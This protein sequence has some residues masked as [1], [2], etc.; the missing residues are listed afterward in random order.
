M[1]KDI[2]QRLLT[3]VPV[4]SGELY[5]VLFEAAAE[6]EWLR[7]A[8]DELVASLTPVSFAG[9]HEAMNRLER[10][11]LAWEEARRG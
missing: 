9:P 10:A 4:E 6:I 8:G 2:V 3:L 11:Y 5:E 7:A 1:S